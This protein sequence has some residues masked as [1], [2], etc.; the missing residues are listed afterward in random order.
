MIGA[1]LAAA[2]AIQGTVHAVGSLADGFGK[3]SDKDKQRINAAQSAL[4]KALSGDSAALQY[5]NQQASN[6]ATDVGKEAFRRALQSYYQQKSG[7]GGAAAYTAPSY[8]PA[9]SNSN[10]SALGSELTD[11]KNN[12]RDDVANTIRRVG[13]GGSNEVANSVAG[14]DA[15]RHGLTIPTNPAQLLIIG[16]IAVGAFLILKKH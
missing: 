9:V 14:T 10:E 8:S 2:S 3:V 13:A 6:S 1:I 12:V 5:M 15:Q 7:Q 16:G 4:T 11:L